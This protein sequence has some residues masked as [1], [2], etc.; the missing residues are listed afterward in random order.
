MLSLALYQS[1][2]PNMFSKLLTCATLV[3]VLV[4]QAHAHAAIAP[5]L[6]VTGA[7]RRSDVQR[8]SNV[9]PCG[10]TNIA[11]NIDGSTPVAAAADGTFTT[12]VTN[13]NA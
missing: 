10:R 3:L 7:P 5:V 1:L 8:P 11:A 4:L 9:K 6:G 12:T 13:F 2:L